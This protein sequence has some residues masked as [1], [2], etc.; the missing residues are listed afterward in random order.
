[1]STNISN[2]LK[3]N[4]DS[5]AGDRIIEAVPEYSHFKEARDEHS[6]AQIVKNGMDLYLTPD[7]TTERLNWFKSEL[8]VGEMLHW[9]EMGGLVPHE[10]IVDSMKLFAKRSH[11]QLPL[12]DRQ[13]SVL[14]LD[15]LKV[16]HPPLEGA[17]LEH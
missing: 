15:P 2:A 11:P 8:P 17:P 9:F 14:A 7:K 16:E 3:I 4:L 13:L 5:P 6:H 12:R 10:K 1:M